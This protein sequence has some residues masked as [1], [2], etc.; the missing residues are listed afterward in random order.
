M[1]FEV[2]VT[3]PPVQPNSVEPP[4]PDR[5]RT[6]A[7]ILIALS[8]ALGAI[9]LILVFV[10]LVVGDDN[11]SASAAAPSTTSEAAPAPPAAAKPSP[12]R[13]PDAP[14]GA[15][16]PRCAPA[17]AS[18]IDLVQPGLIRASWQLTNGAVISIG[19]TTYFGAEIVDQNGAMK[20]RSSVWII[21]NGQVY[22]STGS[23]RN[24]T[25][26]PKASAAPVNI[27]PSDELVQAVD[28]CVVNVTLGR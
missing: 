20:E 17:A 1:T 6:K 2:T 14:F 19:D 24:N 15:S 18:V 21:R 11:E 9:A 25:M 8:A 10:G 22:A 3:Q 28:T 7:L 13:A 26:F 23:A 27:S 12:T 5:R 16:D 4:T